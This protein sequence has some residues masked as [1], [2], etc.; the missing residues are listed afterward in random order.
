MFM[1]KKGSWTTAL[2]KLNLE[3]PLKTIRTHSTFNTF[4]LFLEITVV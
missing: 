4:V 3:G 2:S 1:E